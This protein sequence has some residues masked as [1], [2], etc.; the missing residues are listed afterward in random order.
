MDRIAAIDSMA[1]PVGLLVMGALHDL[2]GTI[3][4]LGADRPFWDILKSAPEFE[5]PDPVDAYSTRTLNQLAETTGATARF[6]F[7]GPPYE[8]FI[9]WAK[10][11]GRAWNSPTGMLVHDHTGLMIS[12]RGALHFDEIL[13]LPAAPAQ[14]PCE[15]CA[16]RPCETACPVS[17]LSVTAPYDVPACHAFL[18]SPAGA[19]CMECGCAVRRACPVSQK[20]G[21]DPDQSA[22]HMAHFHP[23]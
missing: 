19:D 11:S 1:Q 23:T 6:P 9:A 20:F 3:V 5:Q 4:L 14:S 16:D 21:R 18:A 12:Y 8:P 2:G 15:T 10:A 22:H 13:P 7:G 17:A